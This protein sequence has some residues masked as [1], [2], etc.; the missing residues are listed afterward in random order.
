MRNIKLNNSSSKIW[1]NSK[2]Y[3]SKQKGAPVKDRKKL[4]IHSTYMISKS[5]PI[6]FLVNIQCNMHWTQD[7]KCEGDNNR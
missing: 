3:I 6:K 1:K 2:A 4:I 5:E 7:S